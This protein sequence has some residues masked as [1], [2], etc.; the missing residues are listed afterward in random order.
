MASLELSFS[1]SCMA[2]IVAEQDE[3]TTVVRA[4]LVRNEALKQRWLGL[5][6]KDKVGTITTI[7]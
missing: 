7:K 6:L 2:D 1:S 4:L 5:T 3:D